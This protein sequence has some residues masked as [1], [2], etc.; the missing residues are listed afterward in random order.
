MYSA[1]INPNF[2]K[3]YLNLCYPKVYNCCFLDWIIYNI[4]VMFFAEYSG[5]YTTGTNAIP[6]V[7]ESVPNNS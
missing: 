1:L 5:K 4:E 2:S 7:A 6:T 3:D